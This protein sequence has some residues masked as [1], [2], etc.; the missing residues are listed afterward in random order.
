VIVDKEAKKGKRFMSLSAI[1][2]NYE[3]CLYAFSL[4]VNCV[5]NSNDGDKIYKNSN[6]SKEKISDYRKKLKLMSN[7][8]LKKEGLRLLAELGKVREKRNHLV[9]S[10]WYDLPIVKGTISQK[11]LKNN[12]T[13]DLID[14]S[15]DIKQ[16]EQIVE[17]LTWLT[18]DIH[19]HL[20]D[21]HKWNIK[22]HP[23][24]YGVVFDD[25]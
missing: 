5:I 2:I 10:I 21:C 23:Q 20:Y 3:Q 1:V 19:M 15:F 22:R 17:H 9:H 4:I 24:K 11:F 7:V 6:S 18:Y 25:D 14:R 12:K 8:S 13:R 16:A